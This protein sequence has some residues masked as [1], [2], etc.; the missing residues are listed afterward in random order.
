MVGPLSGHYTV[1]LLNL[2]TGPVLVSPDP[3][4]NAAFTLPPATPFAT[5]IWGPSGIFVSA[6]AAESLSV[7]LVP[8]P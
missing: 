4:F 3:S 1:E 6:A 8:N 7:A 5:Y 2:G